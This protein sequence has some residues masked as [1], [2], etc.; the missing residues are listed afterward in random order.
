VIVKQVRLS[1][2]FAAIAI[3][4][5]L[6]AYSYS[7]DWFPI[8]ILRTVKQSVT[9]TN[10]EQ[11]PKAEFDEYGRLSQFEGKTETNCPAWTATTAVILA[12]GQ[13]NS[14]NAADTRF[15][16][17]NDHRILNFYGGRCY[18]AASPLLGATHTGGE[19]LTTMSN[20]LLETNQYSQVIIV[21]AGVG[22]SAI[23]SWQA[24]GDLN[25]ML[26]GVI[27][28]IRGQYPVTHLVWHQGES[29]HYRKTETWRYV[30]R[31]ESMLESIRDLGVDAPIFIALASKCG[32]QPVDI[33]S[34][35]RIA[36]AKLVEKH[37]DVHLAIDSDLALSVS[38][39]AEDD[40]H[41]SATGIEKMA[42]AYAAAILRWDQR[43]SAL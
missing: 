32:R 20:I 21:A 28:D 10:S 14:A 31:F 18:F 17:S 37:P 22:N 5:V 23:N 13:S 4:Y 16:Y 33:S 36:Q 38:D 3:A 43:S 25:S 1:I 26:N 6:G 29:D 11:V 8:S 41:L 15:H 12:F 42:A 2:L 24:G 40:C 9:S 34:A 27:K 39:R 35:V 19:F 7:R 30:D